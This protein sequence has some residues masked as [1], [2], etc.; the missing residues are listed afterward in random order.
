MLLDNKEG[1][2][3]WPKS[4]GLCDMSPPLYHKEVP[5]T[6]VPQGGG[7]ATALV[8]HG[9]ALGPDLAC[10]PAGIEF[11]VA[12]LKSMLLTLG[13]ID[14]RLTVEQAVLLSR[15]EEEYQVRLAPFLCPSHLHSF[16]YFSFLI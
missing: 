12:Q 1:I 2:Q 3:S 16:I 7:P 14:L 8:Q 13:L 5:C 6:F 11:V 4:H 10:V 15:L 9:W